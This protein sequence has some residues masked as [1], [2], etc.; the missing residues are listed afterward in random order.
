MSYHWSYL[1]VQLAKTK[2]ELDFEQTK[3]YNTGNTHKL[4]NLETI[5]PPITLELHV[6]ITQSNAHCLFVAMWLSC[7]PPP[8]P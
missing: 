2:V 3:H 7:L 4:G 8:V 1:T 6:I 5:W